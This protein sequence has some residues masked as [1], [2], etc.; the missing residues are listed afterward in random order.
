MTP[1]NKKIGKNKKQARVLLLAGLFLIGIFSLYRFY[2]ARI[3]SFN[4]QEITK[5]SST[6]GIKPV[7]IKIYPIGVDVAIKEA[8][9][10]DGVWAIYP[11]EAGHLATSAGIGD[12]GNM[13][14]YGHN[15]DSVLGPIRWIKNGAKIEILGD[16]GKTYNYEVVK[17]D[18]V[19]PDNLQYILP[20]NKEVL[21][22]YTCTGFLDGKRFVVIAKRIN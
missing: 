1:S 4:A 15:K 20:Q 2:Q 12:I 13:I 8:I 3:L 10:K 18:T 9:I 16:N 14:I 7:Y 6:T 11:D 21:T 5:F 17:T 19:N 22:L